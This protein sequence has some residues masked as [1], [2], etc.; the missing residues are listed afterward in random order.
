MTSVEWHARSTSNLS[1]VGRTAQEGD[2]S[3]STHAPVTEILVHFNCCQQKVLVYVEIDDM[4][5]IQISVRENDMTLRLC[6]PTSSFI[7]IK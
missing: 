6:Q 1:N 7:G 3:F 5:G 4:F 2:V